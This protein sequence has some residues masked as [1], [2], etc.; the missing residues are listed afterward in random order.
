MIVRSNGTPE[1][2]SEEYKKSLSR[3]LKE[4]KGIIA[5]RLYNCLNSL[6]ELE[7]SA[8]SKEITDEQREA[9]TKV[10][11]DLYR[12]ISI[13]NILCRVQRLFE[14]DKDKLQIR[15]NG[16]FKRLDINVEDEDDFDEDRYLHLFQFDFAPKQD[17]MDLQK[18]LRTGSRDKARIPST[19]IGDISLHEYEKRDGQI[20]RNIE[21]YQ[22]MIEKK[23]NTSYGTFVG[24]PVDTSDPALFGHPG[25]FGTCNSD[26]MEIQVY[27]EEKI[28]KYQNIIQYYQNKKGLTDEEKL[29]IEMA[30]KYNP[31]LLQELGLVPEEFEPAKTYSDVKVLKLTRPNYNVRTLTHYVE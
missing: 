7:F 20:A 4:Y 13:Y 11:F 18:F 9:L 23:K 19:I 15:N 16:W 28:K 3:A 24:T 21:F 6:L 2:D 1:Y 10:D 29:A 30:Q 17:G 8:L 27:R 26:L 22:R 31:L 25:H 14:E 5:N 12:K